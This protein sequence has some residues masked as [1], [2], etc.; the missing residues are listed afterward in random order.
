MYLVLTKCLIFFQYE[1]ISGCANFLIKSFLMYLKSEM[2]LDR[3]LRALNSSLVLLSGYDYFQSV[4]VVRQ[5]QEMGF[6]YLFTFKSIKQY[7][8]I[9]FCPSKGIKISISSPIQRF[10]IHVTYLF[11]PQQNRQLLGLNKHVLPL[12]GILCCW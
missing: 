12:R 4:H 9:L 7:L 1:Y 6:I 8:P 3:M 2:F 10:K 5:N 11:I